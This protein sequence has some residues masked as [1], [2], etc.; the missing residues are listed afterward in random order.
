[1]FASEEMEKTEKEHLILFQKE[2][3]VQETERELSQ[4]CVLIFKQQEIDIFQP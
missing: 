3:K 4:V 1:M 2:L